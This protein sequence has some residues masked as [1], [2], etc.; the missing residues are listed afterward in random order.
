MNTQEDIIRI[1]ITSE[2]RRNFIGSIPVVLEATTGCAGH[3]EV[4]EEFMMWALDNNISY[5]ISH[6]FSLASLGE[7]LHFHIN[8]RNRNDAILFKLTWA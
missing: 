1:E 7:D 3:F 8:L 5:T 2:D 4:K 6:N